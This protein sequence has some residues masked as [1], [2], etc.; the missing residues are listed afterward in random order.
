MKSLTT[1]FSAIIMVLTLGH[2]ASAFD[3]HALDRVSI[4]MKK[5]DVIALLGQPEETDDLGAGLK[6]EVYQVRNMQPLVGAGCIYGSDERLVGQ[7]FIFRGEMARQTADRLQEN[8]FQLAEEKG[9]AFRL[10]G[11]DDD[12]GTPVV[13]NILQSPGLTIVTT[14]DKDFHDRRVTAK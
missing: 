9:D 14:F 5:A 10:L 12:T 2:V 1:A 4:Q 3:I 11:K 13:V 7:T 6:A 8:G